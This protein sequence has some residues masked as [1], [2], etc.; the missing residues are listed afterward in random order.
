MYHMYFYSSRF[1]HSFAQLTTK[2]T[3][4]APYSCRD[5]TVN[6]GAVSF[7]AQELCSSTQHNKE[8]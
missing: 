1:Q 5:F 8:F 6:K 2:N 7:N 3:P 4:P